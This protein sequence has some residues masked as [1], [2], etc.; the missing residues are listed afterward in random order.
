MIKI[1]SVFAILLILCLGVALFVYTAIRKQIC[2][3]QTAQIKRINE[4][5]R[6]EEGKKILERE[7][8]LKC[9]R[10]EKL[11]PILFA[12]YA[13]I[14]IGFIIVGVVGIY[15]CINDVIAGKELMQVLFENKGYYIISPLLV[16]C[17]I[18]RIVNLVKVIKS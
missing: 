16:V 4:L 8:E 12:L 10:A 9:K 11:A 7:S 6:T 18:L 1:L 15:L 5:S 3:R 13:L 14:Y 17:A 2:K